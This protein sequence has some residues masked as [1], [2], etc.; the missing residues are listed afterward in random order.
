[1]KTKL[2]V[3]FILCVTIVTTLFF[4]VR[5]AK[6]DREA[7]PYDYAIITADKEFI[8]VMLVP[9]EQIMK[10]WKH[11]GHE[12]T[13]YETRVFDVEISFEQ[14]RGSIRKIFT[15]RKKYPCSGLYRND[16]SIT[17]IWTVDWYGDVY[18]PGDGEHLIR[19]GPW[20]RQWE[21]GKTS[22]FNGLAVAFYKNGLE[23]A[24]YT[25]NDLVKDKDAIKYSVSHLEWRKTQEFDKDTGLLYIETV[26]NI[27]YTFDIREI[28]QSALGSHNSCKPNYRFVDP[29]S[30]RQSLGIV[31]SFIAFLVLIASARFVD[32]IQKPRK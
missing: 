6:A 13:Y 4:T 20:T 31:I 3:T 23:T 15:L 8:F 19:Q 10:S 28:S 22:N 1:M 2:F 11:F 32:S 25:I 30:T 27:K 29:Q 14:S 12:P 17:P 5:F 16:G 7:A 24:K 21:G 18:L 9:D 26:D